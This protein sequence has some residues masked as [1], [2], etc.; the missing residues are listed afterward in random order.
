MTNILNVQDILAHSGVYP[1]PYKAQ[2]ILDRLPSNFTSE[3]V[4]LVD[5]LVEEYSTI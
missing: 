2:W 1:C 5:S 4:L 3:Q